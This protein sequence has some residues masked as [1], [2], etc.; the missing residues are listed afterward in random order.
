MLTYAGRFSNISPVV[1]DAAAADFTG[2]GVPLSLK[3]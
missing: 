1:D 2:E 3:I